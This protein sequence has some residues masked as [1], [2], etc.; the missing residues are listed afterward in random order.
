MCLAHKMSVDYA[1]G[2]V[3]SVNAECVS[4]KVISSS[5][6]SITSRVDVAVLATVPVQLSNS[7]PAEPYAYSALVW[8]V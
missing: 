5:G 1:T 4:Q 6:S 3:L 7:P 2:C 8:L